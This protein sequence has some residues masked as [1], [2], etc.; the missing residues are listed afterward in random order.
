MNK[1]VRN[2]ITSKPEEDILHHFSPKAMI[3]YL[4]V[5]ILSLCHNILGIRW[6]ETKG[7]CCYRGGL[8]NF[9]PA[10]P[11]YS[12]YELSTSYNKLRCIFLA[13]PVKTEFVDAYDGSIEKHVTFRKST[14][15]GFRYICSF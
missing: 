10:L 8:D 7:C 3:S 9:G 11:K 13:K 1:I 2:N 4:S 15:L 5:S 6:I 14:T 12:P